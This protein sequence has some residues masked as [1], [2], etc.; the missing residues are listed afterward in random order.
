VSEN[1]FDPT[2]IFD[3]WK[4]EL[5]G[6]VTDPSLMSRIETVLLYLWQAERVALKPPDV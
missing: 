4:L 3:R 5:Q 6:C 2:E 1:S